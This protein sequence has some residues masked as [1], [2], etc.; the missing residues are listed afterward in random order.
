MVATL[1]FL[2]KMNLPILTDLCEALEN[3]VS[4]FLLFTDNSSSF[5]DF[6]SNLISYII[7]IEILDLSICCISYAAYGI[8]IG[9]NIFDCPAENHYSVID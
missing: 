1:T 8:K 6:Y 4:P 9:V 7:H 3:A 5:E 2:A